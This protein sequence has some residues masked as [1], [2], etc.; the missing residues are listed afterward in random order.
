MEAT[1]A[2]SQTI[3]AL[4]REI[5]GL[6]DGFRRN[7]LM[8]FAS[9]ISFQVLTAIVPLLLFGFGLLGFLELTEV[10]RREL[11]PAVV[12]SVSP[13]ALTVIDDTVGRVLGSKQL[14]W[15]TAGAALAAWQLSGA[16]R[17][18]MDALNRVQGVEETRGH[19]ARYTR[20]LLSRSPSPGSSCW[21]SRL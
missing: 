1:T 20:S 18:A 12:E 2:R 14:F 16:I 13:A 15:V 21:R 19:V 11:R 17:A 7:D 10:W 6:V 3:R 5:P 9:A 4:P 8:L